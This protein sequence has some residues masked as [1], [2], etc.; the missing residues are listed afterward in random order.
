MYVARLAP[1]Q[2]TCPTSERGQA[3]DATLAE[4]HRGDQE[5]SG[6][7]VSRDLWPRYVLCYVRR[8]LTPQLATAYPHIQ[9]R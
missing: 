9:V 2:E 3:R 8:T 5:Y 4:E 1:G 6:G 7:V